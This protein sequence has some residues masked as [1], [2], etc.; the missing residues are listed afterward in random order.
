MHRYR[1]PEALDWMQSADAKR[2]RHLIRCSFTYC[3]CGTRS[4]AYS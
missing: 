1:I 3:V 4:T 2:S